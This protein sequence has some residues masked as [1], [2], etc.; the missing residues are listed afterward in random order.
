MN[1]YAE[2]VPSGKIKNEGKDDNY[3][4]SSF[5]TIVICCVALLYILIA[6]QQF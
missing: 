1:N 2:G 5:A 6:M 4:V 3:E